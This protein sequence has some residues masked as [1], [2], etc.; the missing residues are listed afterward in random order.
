MPHTI[1]LLSLVSFF[2]DVASDMVIPLLPLLLAGPA[3]GGAL[4]LGVIEG[5]ADAVASMMRL[6][7][8]RRSD[9]SGGQR[10]PLA[11]AGYALSNL[12]RPLLGLMPTW[13]GM[14]ALRAV[15]RVGKGVRSAPRDALLADLVP[16]ARRGAAFGVHRAFDNAGAVLGALAAAWVLSF[17]G[18]DVRAVVLWSALPGVIAVLL[19]AFAV[20]EPGHAKT[21]AAGACAGTGAQ[22]EAP[23]VDVLAAPPPA[24]R[25]YLR[26]L[27][28][29]A[30]SRASETFIVLRGHE[31]GMAP[32]SLLVLWAGLNAAKA[33]T[34]HLGG[35]WA[36]GHGRLQVLRLSWAGNVATA[37][38]LAW[39]PGALA[40][41]VVSLLGSLPVGLGEGAERA[42]VADL[43]PATQ[44]GT[45]YGWYN[46]TT[47]VAAIPA[48]LVFGGLWQYAGAPVAFCAAAVIGGLALWLLPGNPPAVAT[49]RTPA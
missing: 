2:N 39:A 8:G 9:R 38:A 20:R 29:F 26:A 10:K 5:S 14:L 12:V 3:G 40:L 22:Q 42:H 15:D 45:A 24:L 21:L 6:W 43:A 23:G 33:L 46:L 35:G 4:A 19:L 44:R 32:A 1:Y 16:A 36:D 27:L 25:A 7:S 37:A 49:V 47:G 48:G 31:L 41:C 18:A 11:L 34:A 30:L 13:W 17:P 28:L